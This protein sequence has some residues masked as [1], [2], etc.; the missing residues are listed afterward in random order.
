MFKNHSDY[1][2]R[3]FLRTVIGAGALTAFDIAALIA[4]VRSGAGGAWL[5]FAAGVSLTLGI[6]QKDLRW[7]WA[8]RGRKNL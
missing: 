4:G 1:Y 8:G 3:K 5:S 6:F 7:L 2:K